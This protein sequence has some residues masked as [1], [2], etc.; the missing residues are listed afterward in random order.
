MLTDPIL[1]QW[2]AAR[3]HADLVRDGERERLTGQTHP[4]YLP[5]ATSLTLARA[6][7]GAAIVRLGRAFRGTTISMAPRHM[8]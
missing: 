6:P 1:Q 4:W 2:H 3:N 7:L 5:L 8:A